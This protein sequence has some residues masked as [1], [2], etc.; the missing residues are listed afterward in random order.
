M[1]LLFISFTF[2]LLFDD[3]LMKNEKLN[4]IRL[5]NP[6]ETREKAAADVDNTGSEKDKDQPKQVEPKDIATIGDVQEVNQQVEQVFYKKYAVN[7]ELEWASQIGKRILEKGGNAMDAAIAASLSIGV[8]NSFSSGIGGGGFMLIRKK[9]KIKNENTEETASGDA[10]D[11]YDFREISPN[12]ITSEMF[13]KNSEASKTTGLSVAVP[14]EII[15]FF[16]AHKKYGKLPWKDLFEDPIQLSRGF[17]ATKKLAEKIKKNQKYILKDPGLKETYTRNGEIIKEGD[18]VQRTNLAR[19]L[20]ILSENPLDFYTGVIA[21][22]TEKFIKAQGG[23]I[24]KSDLNNYKVVRR[25]VLEDKFYDYK[26][27]STNL[28]TSGV[29]IIEA[30][31]ILEKINIRDLKYFLNSENSY[32]MYH[33]LIETFKFMASERGKFGD[34]KFIADWKN[35]VKN[36]IS[37][38]NLT[39]IFN[40]FDLNKPLPVE[41]YGNNRHF[42]EDHGTTHLNVID[43]DEMIVLITSTVN[44]E[45]GSKLLDPATGIIFNNHIDDFLIPSRD[46][47][48]GQQ[49]MEGN[50][51]EGNKRPFSSAAPTILIKKDEI[52]AIGAAG[53]TRIPTAIITTLAYLLYGNSLENAI[54]LCRIHNQLDQSTFIESTLPDNIVKKLVEM[55]HKIEIS[56]LNSSF[57]SV[58]AIQM[59]KKGNEKKIFAISDSRK[60]GVSTGY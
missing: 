59:L 14:G 33:I 21:E 53:G 52:I 41:E 3:F 48:S 7:T 46:K 42:K 27:I 10:F 13:E 31:K 44:L 43:S 36:L 37:E 35:E 6:T 22:K 32:R 26:V 20:K 56:E 39:R 16:E 23:V 1:L 49:G 50:I 25:S 2:S 30:L 55:G 54:S 11:F 9:E 4:S 57:T 5:E 45:F 24:T 17:K 47:T 40:K 51:L 18:L 60:E 34:P 19:T 38:E 15:G 58:Q 29:F 28:P 12:K 8:V